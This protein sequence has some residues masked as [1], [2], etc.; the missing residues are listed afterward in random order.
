MR[1]FILS[2]SY[3]QFQHYCRQNDIHPAEARWASRYDDI[4]GLDPTTYTIIVLYPILMFQDGA[5]TRFMEEVDRIKA[6]GFKLDEQ[7]T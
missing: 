1:Q 4:A 7:L 3:S 5:Y 6:A 2:Q